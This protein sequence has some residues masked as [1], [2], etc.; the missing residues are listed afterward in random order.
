MARE[1]AI[2]QQ[3]EA[4]A[5]DALDGFKAAT[6][7][8]DKRDYKESARLY[9]VVLK[10]APD[11]DA[12]LRRLGT[13]LVQLGQVPE[14]IALLEKAVKIRR[15]PENLISLAQ[16]LAF[17]GPSVNAGPADK[18]RA[19]LL[20]KEAND[21]IAFD[22]SGYPLLV[23]QLSIELERLEDLRSVMKTITK[24]YPDLMLTHYFNAIL[25][26]SDEEWTKAEDEIRKAESLGLPSEVTEE[27]LASGIHTRA[28][29]WRYAYYSAYLVA[30]WAGGLLFLFVLGKVLSTTTLRSLESSDPNIET[31]SR[32][33]LLRKVYGRLID[34]AGAYYYISIPVVIF[35]VLAVAASITYGFF[36]LGR[37]PIKLVAI[38]VIGALVTVFALI[39]SLFTRIDRRRRLCGPSFVMSPG[40]S[41]PGRSTRSE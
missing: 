25:A 22:D 16:D 29:V 5:P 12:A 20:A 6:V 18:E 4:V 24:K 30:A 27:F 3:L 7:A 23:A 38:V 28:T 37:V 19:L 8:L 2:W 14:G 33:L 15:S 36:L 10:K 39:R 31:G 26:A 11:F 35:L 41:P 40:R 17:P 32:E 9:Q 1:A 13:S 21:K 34:W